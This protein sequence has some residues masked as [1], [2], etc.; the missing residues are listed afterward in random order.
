MFAEGVFFSK[1]RRQRRAIAPTISRWK[2]RFLDSGVDG[3]DTCHSRR[4]GSAGWP[5]MPSAADSRRWTDGV[6][7][8]ENWN[9]Q[10]CIRGGTLDTINPIQSRFHRFSLIFFMDTK[11][12]KIPGNL[13]PCVD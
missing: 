13:L 2:A 8:V 3:L 7:G 10:P 11:D 5:G 6:P 9:E 12:T 4:C 1:I